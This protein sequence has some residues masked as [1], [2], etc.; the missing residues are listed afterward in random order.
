MKCSI[1]V[2]KT[3]KT[4]L[5]KLSKVLKDVEALLLGG[6]DEAVLRGPKVS[7]QSSHIGPD[8]DDPSPMS[9]LMMVDGEGDKAGALSLSRQSVGQDGV[10]SS[11]LSSINS[12]V[13]SPSAIL[14]SGKHNW[15]TR[16]PRRN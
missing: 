4:L 7:C 15:S 3:L 11:S 8:R 2:I 16:P 13:Y 9:L 10:V 14:N 6:M 5:L 1:N 12:S